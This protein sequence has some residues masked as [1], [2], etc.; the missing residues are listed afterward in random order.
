[1]PQ[2]AISENVMIDEAERTRRLRG[3]N[4]ATLAGLLGLMAL[5]YAVTVVRVGGM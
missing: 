5:F 2:S 4:L 1:M 3:R